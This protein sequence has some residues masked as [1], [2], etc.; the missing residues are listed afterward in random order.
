MHQIRFYPYLLHPPYTILNPHTNP[1][2]PR[3]KKQF[4]ITSLLP[5]SH[6]TN[7]ANIIEPKNCLFGRFLFVCLLVCGLLVCLFVCLLVCTL[8]VDVCWFVGLFVCWFVGLLLGLLLVPLFAP[9]MYI[10]RMGYCTFLYCSLYHLGL[11]VWSLLWASVYSS[12]VSISVVTAE[13]YIYKSD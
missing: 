13:L 12:F 10:N 2:P 6:S 8:F 7:H 4:P 1:K 11:F 3:L 9:T 5:I